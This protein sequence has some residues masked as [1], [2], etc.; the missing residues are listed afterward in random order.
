M[1]STVVVIGINGFLGKPVLAGLTGPEFGSQYKIRA[2]TRSSPKEE[3][4][5][6]EYIV[7]SDKAS[8]VKAFD[9]ASAVV[10]LRSAAALG[11]NSPIDA[12]KEAG[13]KTYVT[14]DFGI[15]Y[16]EDDELTAPF[17]GKKESAAAVRAAG[18]RLVQ[19][20]TGYFAEGSLGAFKQLVYIDEKN[21]VAE[22]VEGLNHRISISALRDVGLVVAGVL[23][24]PADQV[25]EIV[26]VQSFS[27]TP[28]E[29]AD[30]Y[31]KT[32]GRQLTTKA[33]TKQSVVDAAKRAIS[34]GFKE[35]TFFDVLRGV[36]AIAPK[37]IDFS[38]N[39]ISSQIAAG[40]FQYTTLEQV[41][42]GWK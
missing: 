40:K 6:V 16:Y 31:T 13:V 8:Y 28:Q 24:L 14:S 10:D 5:N 29:I 42:S 27:V 21:G 19:I 22:Q 17:N 37:A 25:P 36:S 11:D 4:P 41:A 20:Q 30:L 34:T 15:N 26:P 33:V 23:A 12:A 7:A 3:L 2:V 9:G 1:T 18:L 39:N 38:R 35:G 32:T